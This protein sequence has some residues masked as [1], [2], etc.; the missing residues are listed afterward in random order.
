MTLYR[1]GIH[2]VSS[3]LVRILLGL[4]CFAGI[5]VV[6]SHQFALGSPEPPLSTTKGWGVLLSEGQIV[7]WARSKLTE[8][9]DDLTLGFPGYLTMHSESYTRN[10]A[11][12]AAEVFC[13]SLRL[14]LGMIVLLL[15]SL[16]TRFLVMSERYPAYCCQVCGYDLRYKTSGICPECGSASE[17]ISSK[18]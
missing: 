10:R 3:K 17:E 15:L 12:Y 9:S 4:L 6:L 8:F 18:Q 2:F 7:V 14:P 11:L 1:A 5:L 13:I 16:F